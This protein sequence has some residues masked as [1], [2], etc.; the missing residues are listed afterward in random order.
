M[1]G[2]IIIGATEPLEAQFTLAGVP[3][4]TSIG[5][6]FLRRTDDDTYYNGATHQA[7]RIALAMTEI[8]DTEATGW[9]KHN[10]NTTGISAGS[11]NVE[12]EDTTA[13]S[14]NPL[15][16]YTIKLIENTVI[17]NQVS[18][19]AKIDILDTNVDTGLVN[20]GNIEAK[21][22]IVDGN[23]DTGLVNDT[24]IEAKLDIVDGNVDSSLVNQTNIEG[25]ID[26]VD[27]VVDAVKAKTD[28]LP[29]DP[30]SEAQ[31][32]TNKASVIAE[33]DVNEAKL[34]IIDVNVDAIK[35]K[36]DALPADIASETNATANK[37]SIISE[38]D[39]N[40]AK[41]DIIDANVDAI[42][43]KT[44]ALPADIASETN[45][46]SNTTDIIAEIDAN[47]AKID[48]ID[49]NVDASLVNQVTIE[50]KVDILDSNVDTVK[51][52]TDNLPSDPTS[53]AQAIVNM[54]DI[55]A[56]IASENDDAE[57]N[58]VGLADYN[59]TTSILT[60]YKKD[61]P[62]VVHQAFDIKDK[63]GNPAGLNPPF[64][65]VPI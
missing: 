44:D 55:I 15:E 38:V 51:A 18:I 30:T 23:V 36:T 5:Q 6:V 10:F 21:V 26:T 25:K 60:L 56:E 52:K 11:Y 9:H 1:S 20:D 59:S 50:G 41:I 14:D 3:S 64:K 17:D 2:D 46:T 34:D 42:K 54:N 65:R 28:N 49:A 47:E 62:T 4:T 31:A 22:D 45:A 61:Q 19:E 43:L 13:N 33:V 8:D 63:N 39:D 29:A 57:A 16:A 24:N 27:T 40:E 37:T 7:T 53:E 58:A 35:V 32:T 12:T 48:T